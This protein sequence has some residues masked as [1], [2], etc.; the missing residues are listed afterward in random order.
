MAAD[1]DST[2]AALLIG[3]KLG[4][5]AEAL[6]DL[7][8]DALEPDGRRLRLSGGPKSVPPSPALI[9]AVHYQARL[10]ASN[11]RARCQGR[12]KIRPLLPVENQAT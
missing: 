8:M 7:K 6:A 11:G 12:L 1:T 9:L 4:A 2:A 10:W 5:S 3:E